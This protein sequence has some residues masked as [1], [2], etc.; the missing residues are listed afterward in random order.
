MTFKSRKSLF[1]KPRKNAVAPVVVK[2]KGGLGFVLWRG[3]KWMCMSLGFFMILSLISGIIFSSIFFKNQAAEMPDKS[4]LL[5]QL[6]DS[7]LEHPNE[8]GGYSFDKPLTIG[9]MIKALEAGKKDPRV[10]GFVMTFEGGNLNLAHIQE[11]RSVIKDF[12]ESGK[13][14]YIYGT[15]YGGFGSGLGQY[16]LASSF[17]KIFMQPVGSVN[18]SGIYAEL[19][20]ARAL[21]DK[22]GIAPQIIARKEYKSVF[23]AVTDKDIT[24]PVRKMMTSLLGDIQGHIL[25]EIAADRGFGKAELQAIVDAALYT[26]TESVDMK[27]VDELVYVDQ[28]TDKI[29]DIITAGNKALYDDVMFVA[30]DHYASVVRQEKR[31][32]LA[33]RE[34][35]KKPSVALIYAVGTIVEHADSSPSGLSS[36]DDVAGAIDFAAEQDE[37][38]GIIIRVASPG[39]SPAASETI[40]RSVV[41]A[42]EQGKF[43]VVS[44]GDMAASGGY[45]ISADADY[46]YALPG[47]LTGSIGVAGGK[48]ALQEMWS[49]IGVNWA[50]IGF[51]QNADIWSFNEPFS[52]EGRARF[53][54]IMDMIYDAFVTRVAEG[55]GMSFDDAEQIARGR[56]WSGYQALEVGLVDELGG[57]NEALDYAA[58]KI[59][60]KDRNDIN[61]VALPAAKTAFELVMEL[62]E[63]QVRAGQNLNVLST[64]IS[65]DAARAVRNELII[66]Q[67]PVSAYQTPVRLK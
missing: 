43:V 27:L 17:D 66:H 63:G 14:A 12:R 60:L 42:K 16:Y 23:S 2:K 48:F 9:M 24:E 5:L 45:W 65:N 4:V 6:T 36:A 59:G 8:A 46:I 35:K 39:G 56:V 52:E 15:S 1:F 22:M 37:V 18:I 62:F 34:G 49:K 7:V 19:P 67:Q 61:V 32:R 57:L 51:G 25:S 55:R 40:R 3:F 64:F 29:K 28:L 53:E 13:F 58:R 21:L 11:L 38:E 10:N 47:T 41:K 44:M 31:E 50:T 54:K 20:Y 30:L 33:A 26:D